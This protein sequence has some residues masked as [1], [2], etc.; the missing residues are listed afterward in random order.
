[1]L[2]G[3]G[4]L[5]A[6][7]KALQL[8]AFDFLEKPLRGLAALQNSVRNAV[9]H[10]QLRAERDRLHRELAERNT[11]LGEH[12]DV[13]ERAYRLLR[14]R[15]DNVRADLHTAGIIQR[16]LLPQ[17]APR[18]TGMQFHA[19]YRPS[20]SIGGDLYDVVRLDARHSAL[21]IAD[22]AG[23]GL[24]AA[25]LA[26][27][28]RSQLS[29][30]E[31]GSR[32]PLRPGE[33]LRS[34]NRALCQRIPESGLFLTAAY[35]LLDTQ[36]RKATFASAGHPP[37]L[38][39][40]SGG[41]CERIFHSGPA[42]GLYAE[43]EFAELEVALEPGDRLLFHS[44]GVYAA[45]PEGDASAS[46]KIAAILSRGR[47]RGVEAL[48]HL[49]APSGAPG[50]R[51]GEPPEDDVTLLLLDVTPGASQLDNGDLSPLP[52]PASASTGCEILVGSDPHREI[53]SIQGRGAWEHSAQ[54]HAE[55][56]AAIAA[57][58][59]VLIDMTLCQFLDSSFLGALHEL[60]E[61]A[62]EADVELRL[63]G[64]TFAVEDLFSELGM[65]GVMEHVVPRMLPLPTR[66]EPLASAVDARSRA[67]F[68][69]RV[70]EKLAGLSDRNRREFD[71]LVTLLRREVGAAPH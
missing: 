33:L 71:P 10:Q 48:R 9:A 54:F 36:S 37:L 45:L 16:A 25:M 52:A 8:G 1:V 66:M 24:S 3:Y 70:H 61:R 57:G 43:A 65:T 18:L 27:L 31:P 46:E 23:H 11:Q 63:Q 15:A 41:E 49:L 26:V 12:V 56:A 5:D 22:A 59:T 28:F 14:E 4:T 69:L 30:L 60:S 32:R 39:L 58:R 21:L 55:C 34:A 35:C 44:D 62:E 50:P 19:L 51:D 68:T 53:F 20:Q 6:A 7:V 67:S 64:V 38:L 40:R 42:L 2:T 29:F 47:E 17:V 13:L